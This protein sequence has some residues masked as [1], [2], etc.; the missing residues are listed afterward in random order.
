MG[1]LVFSS[2]LPLQPFLY[3]AVESDSH[4]PDSSQVPTTSFSLEENGK[5]SSAGDIG[6]SL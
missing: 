6:C 3:P 2:E 1:L 4:A 5:V